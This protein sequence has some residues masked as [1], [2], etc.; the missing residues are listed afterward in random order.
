MTSEFPHDDKWRG[1]EIGELGHL[2]KHRHLFESREVWA[3][4]AAL[5]AR[6]P[7]LIRGEPGTGKSELAR[8]AAEVLHRPLVTEV[9]SSRTEPSDLHWKFDAVARLGQAQLLGVTG[10][11]DRLESLREQLFLAPGSLWWVFDWKGAEMQYNAAS[12]KGAR[13]REPKPEWNWKPE[14]GTVLLIDEIDKA[15]PDL[16]NGLL[17]SLG[18]GEF[19]VQHV[20]DAVRCS[21]ANEPPLVIITTNEEREL[22]AA[23]VRRCLV[24]KL[25]LPEGEALK[26]WLIARGK[27]H[28]GTGI[29]E[30]IYERAA[31]LLVDE[32]N[33]QGTEQLVRPGQAEY[34]DLLRAVL[35]VANKD[36]LLQDAVLTELS[37]YALRKNANQ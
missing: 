18:N 13:P 21:K 32:R 36:R 25:A 12:V 27:A 31:S 26:P 22:P 11:T 5:G 8:A 14:Q 2:P 17:E 7:L 29:D 24:L 1:V 16:P 37:G 28:F 4:K 10:A 33:A 30:E 20:K 3:I 15:D 19:N 9:I 23:F 6:R 34:L 35:D